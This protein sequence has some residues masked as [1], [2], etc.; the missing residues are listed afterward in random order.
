MLLKPCGFVILGFYYLKTVGKLLQ[1]LFSI[2]KE[3]FLIFVTDM[4]SS[5][6]RNLIF[7]LLT[8]FKVNT[9]KALHFLVVYVHQAYLW[10]RGLFIVL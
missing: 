7:T 10:A 9:P 6:E 8:I 3:Y 5:Q 4:L 2:S 1:S